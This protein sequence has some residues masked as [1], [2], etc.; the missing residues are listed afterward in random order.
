M[1]APRHS[2]ARIQLNKKLTVSI[3]Y[4][5][6]HGLSQQTNHLQRNFTS[7]L[8][9]SG[10]SQRVIS[11]ARQMGITTTCR[12]GMRDSRK[13]M[14]ITTTCRT[15]MRD[16]RKKS[17]SNMDK[18]NSAIQE[19]LDSG[20]LIVCI[21]DD[22]HHYHAIRRPDSSTK[23]SSGADMCTTVIRI[24]PSIPAIL[25]TD[26]SRLH[27][28]EGVDIDRLEETMTSVDSMQR[29]GQTFAN[30]M[31]NWMTSSFFDPKTEKK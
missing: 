11:A 24:F 16:S 12:T 8:R 25:R 20:H 31:P 4:N 23:T 22:Y 18:V 19:A 14:G 30:S 26:T 13:K 29:L 5:L 28:P 21:I 3:I 6:C 7:Q 9:L 15:G 10:T 17:E 27:N 1:T 2:K